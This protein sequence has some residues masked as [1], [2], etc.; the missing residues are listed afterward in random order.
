MDPKKMKE[1]SDLASHQ[2]KLA[3]DYEKERKK[4]GQ[5]KADLDLILAANLPEI[6]KEKANAGIDMAY[7]MLMENNDVASKL[8]KEWKICESNYQGLEKLI[9]AHQAKIMME[10]SILKYTIQGEKYS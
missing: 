3:G 7:L 10:Q 4:A 9:E 2:I 8:Y 1:L 5:A 6:R